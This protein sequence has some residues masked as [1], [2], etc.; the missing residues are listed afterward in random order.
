MDFDFFRFLSWSVVI[1][2]KHYYLFNFWLTSPLIKLWFQLQFK[3][4]NQRIIISYYHKYNLMQIYS[5]RDLKESTEQTF[6]ICL[7]ISSLRT[8]LSLF[9]RIFFWNLLSKFSLFIDFSFEQSFNHDTDCIL[10][11]VVN[12]SITYDIYLF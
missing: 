12:I 4:P 2:S 8:C 11:S 1:E 7:M 9:M 3:G 6:Q 10:Y 5:E